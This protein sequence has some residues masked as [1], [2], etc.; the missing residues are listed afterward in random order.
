MKG[1]IAPPTFVAQSPLQ[2]HIRDGGHSEQVG[3][4]RCGIIQ[5]ANMHTNFKFILSIFCRTDSVIF[6]AQYLQ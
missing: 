4:K 5:E 3:S 2:R 6:T 1:I